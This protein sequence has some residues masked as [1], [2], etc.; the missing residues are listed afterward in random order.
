MAVRVQ[1]RRSHCTEA[2]MSRHPD[3]STVASLDLSRYLGTWYEIARLPIRFEDADCTDVSAHYSLDAD[4]GIRVQNR[5]FTANGELEEAVGQA[6][7]IDETHAR[8]EVT[9]LPEGLR[10]IPFTKG[11]Y[12]VM[13]IDADYTAALVG[14]PDRKYLWLLARLPQ[15][16]ENIAQ[17]YL[18]HAREQGFDLAPLIHTPHTGRLTEQPLP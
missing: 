6:R 9:F 17:T 14:S 2:A 7:A 11:D 8:L 12:W 1:L 16:D 10:W 18:A 5:C 3:L 4:G 15:L 13:R